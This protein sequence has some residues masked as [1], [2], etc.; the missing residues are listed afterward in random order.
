MIGVVKIGGA[1]GNA[2]GPL[3]DEIARRTRGG[4]RWIVVHGASGAMDALCAER[5]IDVRMVTS[6]SGYKSRFVGER[7][8]AVFRDAALSYGASIAEEL[9]AR[10]AKPELFDPEREGHAE[11]ERKDFLRECVNGRTRILR[12]NYS[13]TV[14]KTEVRPFAAALDKGLVPVVPPLALDAELGI[15]LNV[16][17]DRLAARIAAAVNTE[18]LVILSNVAGLLKSAGDESTLIKS[19]RLADWDILEHYAQGGMKRKLVACREALDLSVPK[20]YIADGRVKEPIANAFG[21]NS[22]CFAR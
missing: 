4:E 18:A 17:G 9:S 2:V 6:P 20:V 13:G 11:A 22:T 8:R 7:E 16:D 5:G 14:T 12:G 1:A 21:G 3:A 10:G 19:G 15:S